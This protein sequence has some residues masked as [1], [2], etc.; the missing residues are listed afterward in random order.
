MPE[1]FLIFHCSITLFFQKTRTLV[2]KRKVYEVLIRLCRRLEGTGKLSLRKEYMTKEKKV[3][4]WTFTLGNGKVVTVDYYPRWSYC[5]EDDLKYRTDHFELR[6]EAISST[7]YRSHFA[8]V[9]PDPN[10][11][12]EKEAYDFIKK[13][14]VELSGIGFEEWEG[15]MELF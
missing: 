15:Q 14:I 6:G 3:I 11:D 2:F 1:G 10:Y 9:D 12:G 7:G 4:H 13:M 5:Y 8:I